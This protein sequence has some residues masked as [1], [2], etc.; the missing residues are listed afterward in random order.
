MPTPTNLSPEEFIQEIKSWGASNDSLIKV[1]RMKKGN[2]VYCRVVLPNNGEVLQT[3]VLLNRFDEFD[4]MNLKVVSVP[5]IWDD[6][7]GILK[8][9]EEKLEELNASNT[10]AAPNSYKNIQFG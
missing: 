5:A 7:T 8:K 3:R 2:F 10:I 6:E 1:R 4:W 9:I